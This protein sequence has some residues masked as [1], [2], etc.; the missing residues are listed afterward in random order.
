MI[1]FNIISMEENNNKKVAW[2][3]YIKWDDQTYY[4][5]KLYPNVY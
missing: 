4:N 5:L 3:L 1:D 2:K